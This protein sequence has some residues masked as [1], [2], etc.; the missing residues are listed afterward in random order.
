MQ[1]L[2]QNLHGPRRFAVTTHAEVTPEIV[3]P[4]LRRRVFKDGG[5]SAYQ[6][7]P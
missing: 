7:L 1:R 4:C 6:R 3:V 5:P 2:R